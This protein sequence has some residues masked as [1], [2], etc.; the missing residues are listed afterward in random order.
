MRVIILKQRE[1]SFG[2]I[3]DTDSFE[4]Y[5]NNYIDK[6]EKSKNI[7]E[8]KFHINYN[9]IICTILYENLI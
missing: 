2:T 8:V 7:L 5:V 4:F 9:K 6:I 3:E 1:N